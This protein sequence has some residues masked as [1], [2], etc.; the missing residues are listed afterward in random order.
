MSDE[1]DFNDIDELM[2]FDPLGLS[3]QN[4][5]RII[6]YQRKNRALR[7]QGVRPKKSRGEAAPAVQLM[8]ARIKDWDPDP[9]LKP[10]PYKNKDQLLY[11][12]VAYLDEFKDD[13]CK[14][15]ILENGKPAVELSFKFQLDFGPRTTYKIPDGDMNH[16]M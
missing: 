1:D 15:L 12:V 9:T 10:F 5:D 16:D 6:A 8:L 14:T 4:L 2:A 3:K 13:P 7:E 11:L